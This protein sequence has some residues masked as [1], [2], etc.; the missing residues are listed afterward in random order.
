M[1]NIWLHFQQLAL[2]NDP[3]FAYAQPAEPPAVGVV[4]EVVVAVEGVVAVEKVVVAVEG[5]VAVEE[6]VVAVEEVV[7][8]H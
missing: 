5:V 3:P 6:V 7:R 2:E 4:E 1:P 8:P